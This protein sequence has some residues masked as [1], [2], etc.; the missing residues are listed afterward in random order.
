MNQKHRQLFLPILV[1]LFICSIAL[2]YMDDVMSLPNETSERIFYPPPI[3]QYPAQ[4]LPFL[5]V[6]PGP[7]QTPAPVPTLHPGLQLRWD[8]KGHI[9]FDNYYWN[10]GTHEHRVVDRQIDA[11]TVRILARSW[12]SPNPFNWPEENWYCHYNSHTNHPETC[13]SQ[14]DP[15][16]K[17]GYPWILPKELELVNARPV[18]ID[19]QSVSVTGPHTYLT[20]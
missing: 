11:D 8:G 15:A 13:S 12:Y 18:T 5:A 7:T 14:G 19:G 3:G 17:W 4:F 10:P 6:I 20:G 2:V 1:C 16:W 9:Y